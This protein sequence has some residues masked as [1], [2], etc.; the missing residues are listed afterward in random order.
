M[1]EELSVESELLRHRFHVQNAMVYFHQPLGEIQC[2]LCQANVALNTNQ[3]G[4]NGRMSAFHVP[5]ARRFSSLELIN[6]L[7]NYAVEDARL[8]LP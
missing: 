5:P 6:D 4:R 1:D 3:L 7:R 8:S 2:E